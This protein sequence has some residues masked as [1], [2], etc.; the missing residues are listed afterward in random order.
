MLCPYCNTEYTN[1]HPCFCHPPVASRS[2]EQHPMRAVDD[3]PTFPIAW[4]SHRGARL[5]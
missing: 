4:N 3:C 2:G 5:D 1:E